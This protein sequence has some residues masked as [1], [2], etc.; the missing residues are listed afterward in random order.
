[1]TLLDQ[2]LGSHADAPH[3]GR[4]PPI[5]SVGAEVLPLATSADACR[6]RRPRCVNPDIKSTYSRSLTPPFSNL[7]NC[8]LHAAACQTRSCVDVITGE[9]S[10]EAAEWCPRDG[11]LGQ[12]RSSLAPVDILASTHS[13]AIPPRICQISA[14]VIARLESH[15]DS[16]WPILGA[17][18][19]QFPARR[20]L[21]A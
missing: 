20:Q 3:K 15:D 8:W 1:M 18:D 11:A 13:S 2:G 6:G 17:N 21:L 14:S 4:E 10:H 12:I 7:T 9:R 19:S 16:P 5:W